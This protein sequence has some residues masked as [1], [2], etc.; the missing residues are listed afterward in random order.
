MKKFWKALGITALAAAVPVR[1][2]KNEETGKKTYQSLLASVVVGPNENGEKT[3][4]AINIG[5]GVLINAVCGLISSKKETVLFADDD[6]EAAVVTDVIDMTQTA[7]EE[8][9]PAGEADAPE[10]DAPAGEEG[11]SEEATEEDFDPEL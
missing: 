1:F 11:T 3:V 5:D 6:P 2:R 10:E 8:D 9:A 4:I 7:Q